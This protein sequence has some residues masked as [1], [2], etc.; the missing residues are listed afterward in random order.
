M[1]EKLASI[2]KVG[3]A[4]GSGGLTLVGEYSNTGTVDVSS[5]LKTGDTVDNF[6]IEPTKLYDSASFSYGG[7]GC[8]G[9]TAVTKSLNGTTLNVTYSHTTSRNFGNCSASF[10]Y[11]VWYVG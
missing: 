6:I 9:N 4:G 11:K 1:A 10:D 7:Y 3:G 2:K 8:S 5:V